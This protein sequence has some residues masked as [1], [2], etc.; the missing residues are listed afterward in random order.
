MSE[1][2]SKPQVS[3]SCITYN[4]APFIRECLDSFL[5]QKTCFPF[6]VLIHDDASTDGTAE[7]I[8]EYQAKYPN[9]VKPIF[10]KKNLYSQGV[11]MIN[12][13]NYERAQ[14]KYIALCEGDDFWT[15]PGKLQIQY[16]L[17][18]KNPD[19]SVCYHGRYIIDHIRKIYYPEPELPPIPENRDEVLKEILFGKGVMTQCLFFRSSALKKCFDDILQW[20]KDFPMGDLQTLFFLAQEGEVK[21]LPRRM[22]VYRQ[23]ENSVSSYGKSQKQQQKRIDF[24]TRSIEWPVLQA[25]RLG[26]PEWENAIRDYYLSQTKPA[27][28]LMSRRKSIRETFARLYLNFVIFKS[29]IKF[30]YYMKKHNSKLKSQSLGAR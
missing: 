1:N 20:S 4:Q 16:D 13:F 5:M 7:I 8:K 12:R 10:R 25:K 3:I 29:S 14:G 19:C 22:A 28:A 15:D 11:R 30:R 9:I 26:H 23:A 21:Y 27:N 6:E 18:E 2:P 24:F 17:M